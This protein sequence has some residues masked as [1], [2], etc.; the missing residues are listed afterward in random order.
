MSKNEY[1]GVGKEHH[2]VKVHPDGMILKLDDGSVWDVR[3]GPSTK[4]ALW[5]PLQRII[6][7]AIQGASGSY[8]LKNLDTS[9][10]D[11]VEVNFKKYHL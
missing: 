3:V 10:P 5:Y 9:G 4:V 11:V 2:I 7:E 1:S 6:V 8:S